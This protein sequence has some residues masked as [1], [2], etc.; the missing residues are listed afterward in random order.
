MRDLGLGDEALEGRGP[1]GG[2][3]VGGHPVGARARD[4]T[5]HHRV[6]R[7]VRRELD[8]HAFRQ[9]QQ[10]GLGEPV[11]R[12]RPDEPRRRAHVD[13]A[14]PAEFLHTGQHALGREEHRLEVRAHHVVPI[15][16]GERAEGGVGEGTCVVHEDARRPQCGLHLAHETAHVVG[17]RHIG[18][19]SLSLRAGRADRR[20]H[21]LGPGPR[22]PVVH[23]HA[24]AT[25]GERLCDVHAGAGRGAGDQGDLPLQ[26]PFLGH[27]ILLHG[28]TSSDQIEVV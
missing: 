21:P 16:L 18:L 28:S 9:V 24:G 17:H 23:R 13:D 27:P 3:L 15:A 6:D 8:R 25:A 14:T 10:R 7:H 26:E 22:A 11:D 2:C 19:K 4:L 1:D 20:H 5:R 12:V